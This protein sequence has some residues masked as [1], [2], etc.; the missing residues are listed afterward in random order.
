MLALRRQRVVDDGWYDR[1]QE[2]PRG[3]PAMLGV[4]IGALQIVDVR[5]DMHVGRIGKIAEHA[6]AADAVEDAVLRWALAG[7]V[8]LERGRKGAIA[9]DLAHHLGR[10]VLLAD[11]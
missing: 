1:R 11:E 7:N 10:Q 2:W 9:L 8:H 6:I 3:V 4:V 5:R